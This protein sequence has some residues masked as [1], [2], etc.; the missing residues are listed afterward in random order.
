[1]IRNRIVT[2]LTM[3]MLVHKLQYGYAEAKDPQM[4]LKFVHE[5]SAELNTTVR[6][7]QFYTEKFEPTN[8]V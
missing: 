3:R 5:L 6:I 8:P 4:H 1:M 7:C 2:H